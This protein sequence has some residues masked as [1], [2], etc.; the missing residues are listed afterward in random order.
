VR[1]RVIDLFRRMTVSLLRCCIVAGGVLLSCEGTGPTSAD[2]DTIVVQA[3]LFAGKPLDAVKLKRLGKT[4][5]STMESI[6]IEDK[7]T[8]EISTIDT[9]VY[10]VSD[11]YIDDA[12]VTITG[13]G[14]TWSLMSSGE[15]LYRDASGTFIP[16]E[17][18][19]Y[20]IDISAGGNTAW[21][22]TTVPARQG[23]LFISRDT[24]YLG[25]APIDTCGKY[26]CPDDKGGMKKVASGGVPDT[27]RS[28]T[29]KWNGVPGEYIYYRYAV[30]D[31]SG[32]G[33][34]TLDSLRFSCEVPD[35]YGGSW[36]WSSDSTG[37]NFTVTA[38]CNITLYRTAPEFRYLVN[39][40]MYDSTRQD[41]WIGSPCN[42]NGGLGF[43]TS[44]CSDTFSFDIVPWTGN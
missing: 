7:E 36:D 32:S 13:G 34:S 39:D 37:M 38:H 31:G 27:L 29:V 25:A 28:L 1:K 11:R 44:F 40:M 6:D 30:D 18:I 15:G 17:G 5:V 10:L 33:F 12:A 24:I 22:Q 3:Y 4:I 16:A 42:I 19:T 43:F 9:V 41:L 21:A 20:R 35:E 14:V 2:L 8:G 23:G 26:G